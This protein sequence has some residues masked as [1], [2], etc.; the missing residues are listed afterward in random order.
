[1]SKLTKIMMLCRNWR[2]VKEVVNSYI[3][4]T[5][6]RADGFWG[7]VSEQD[8]QAVID[9]ARRAAQYSGPIIEI[10]TLFG[11]TAQV[12]AAHKPV[13]KPLLCVDDF[14][15]N[16]LFLTRDDHH[17]FTKHILYYCTMHCKTQIIRE[18]KRKFYQN[19]TGPRPSMVFIDAFHQYKSVMED[20]RWATALQ[21][22]I[23]SGHDYCDKYPGVSRAVD[24][25]FGDR[26]FVQG[27]VWAVINV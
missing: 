23:I 26:V 25:T 2:F 9:L 16:P 1:M 12:L 20:L 27:W 10:G 6:T 17:T 21:V 18:N 15:W 19:Y 3:Y 4:F 24:E 11:L 14:S 5:E 22:P 13:D 8:H 7:T